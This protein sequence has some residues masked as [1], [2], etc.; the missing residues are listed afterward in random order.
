MSEWYARWFNED[1]L[2]LY[3]HRDDADAARAVTLVRSLAPLQAGARVL[4]V[5][6]GPGRH[7]RLLHDAGFR[8]TGLDLSAVLLRRARA[9]TSAPLVRAD[10]R[11]LPIRA[12]SMDLVVNLFTSFGYFEDDAA[13]AAVI[14]GMAETL[15]PGGRLILDFLNAADVRRALDGAAAEPVA[16][17]NGS[18]SVKTLADDGRYVVKTIT[19][20]DGTVH[21]ERVRLLEASLLERM[22][23]AAGLTV[24]ARHGDYGGGP[25][26]ASAPRV[27][28]AGRCG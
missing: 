4:D 20:A 11:A 8:V 5:G 27:I 6:C 26:I 12:R 21:V 16:G 17:P 22:F 24:E 1:Y 13:H 18:W 7:T 25:M 10:M 14:R 19:L 15:A 23:E 28:L 2:A 3:P 9:A